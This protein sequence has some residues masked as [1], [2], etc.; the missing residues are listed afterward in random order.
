MDLP[1]EWWRLY[2]SEQLNALIEE[3]LKQNPNLK[4]ASA[5]LKVAR[6][7]RLAQCGGYFPSISAMFGGNDNQTSS[8]ITPFPANNSLYYGLFTPQVSVAYTPDVFGL[9]RRTV[10]SLQ[11]QEDQAK[12]QLIAAQIALTANVVQTAIQEAS[13]E[14]QL[15]ATH[16]LIDAEKKVLGVI[17]VQFSKGYAS[18]LDVAAQESLLAQTEASLPPLQKQMD[19]QRDLLAVLAGGYPSNYTAESFRLSRLTLPSDLPL[20]IPSVLV[21]QRPD[22]RQAEANIHQACAQVG[23]A[24]A[25]RFPNLTINGNLGTMATQFGMMFAGGMGFYTIGAGIAQP[26]FEGG[27]L[28]HKERAARAA[29]VQAG[30][31]Y[32][33]TVLSALQN[34][35]DTL[36]ALNHDAEALRLAVDAERAAKTT[37]DVTAS[38]FKAGYTNNLAL[39]QAEQ[40]YQQALIARTQAQA[41][42]FSDTAA[43]FLSLGGGWWNLPEFAN[44][45]SH[46]KL[47]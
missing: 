40:T 13:L 15:E 12:E 33:A 30:E 26:L 31:Q 18:R 34:V 25:N 20:S 36:S 17:K 1:G 2:R 24:V 4:A 28:L 29:L 46:A 3:S 32:K 8:A 44:P 41:A 7:N 39:F 22:V 9:N 16:A 43:L 11:A 47:P 42:R 23:I 14:D 21:R 38:Q 6:E 35:A 10:E 19:Q 27:M 37:L 5:S 45:P